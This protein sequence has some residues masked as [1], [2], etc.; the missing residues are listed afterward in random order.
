MAFGVSLLCT[1]HWGSNEEKKN[2]YQDGIN[3]KRFR[4]Y[5]EATKTFDIGM[6]HPLP[7]HPKT[8]TDLIS[9]IINS[10]VIYKARDYASFRER[11]KHVSLYFWHF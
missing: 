6:Q 10:C 8:T 11:L 2:E 3:S 1:F 4:F 5:L 7:K 9:L